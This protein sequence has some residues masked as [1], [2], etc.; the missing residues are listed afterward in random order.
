MSGKRL[1]DGVA[2]LKASTAVASKHVALRRHQVNV[3]GRTSSIAR[4]FK[5]QMER[6]TSIVKSIPGNATK[7]EVSQT[8]VDENIA[9]FEKNSGL[10]KD[11]RYKKLE[12]NTNVQP[13]PIS[14]DVEREKGNS[15]FLHDGAS[16][17]IRS[18]ENGSGIDNRT[19]S[20]LLR[21]GLGR[22]TSI[23]NDEGIEKVLQPVSP[24][25][26][27]IPVPGIQSALLN[28]N[29][30]RD[31]QKHDD[32]DIP[33]TFAE[34]QTVS[35]QVLQDI[36]YTPTRKLSQISSSLPPLKLP[37]VTMV[38]E[39]TQELNGQ[40]SS[41]VSNQDVLYSAVMKQTIRTPIPEEQAVPEQR[42]T[43]DE[44]LPEIFHSPRVA[45]MLRE[46]PKRALAVENP[47]LHIGQGPLLK[48]RELAQGRNQEKVK[49]WSSGQNLPRNIDD[50][51]PVYLL[52]TL[53]E[54]DTE[55]VR[56][57]VAE[58]LAKDSRS[59]YSATRGVRIDI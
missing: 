53:R 56:N 20:D 55:E 48:S 5:S 46:K 14:V 50:S 49:I 32:K 26:D 45:K 9:A 16:P 24:V 29:G 15:Q 22:G 2:L 3:Y 58:D 17:P 10:G 25:R 51:E 27:A 52:G 34:T 36:F 59:T 57:N 39:H 31:L 11:H 8:G 30:G 12:T 41:E 6:V 40:V 35:S 47:S 13:L 4:V 54:A 42:Q 23:S 28:S 1:L 44:M 19:S 7:M 21:S 38:T 18:I 37:M 33:S 43:S